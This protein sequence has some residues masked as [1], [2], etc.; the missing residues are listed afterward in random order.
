MWAE[1]TVFEGIRNRRI[2]W[3]IRKFDEKVDEDPIRIRGAAM[4]EAEE[5]MRRAVAE[6]DHN[7]RNQLT[8][9]IP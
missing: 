3:D 4:W 8:I 7:S 9:R 1:W 6:R 2:S 5:T